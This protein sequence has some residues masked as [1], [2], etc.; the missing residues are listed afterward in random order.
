MKPRTLFRRGFGAAVAG[1]YLVT[2]ALTGASASAQSAAPKPGGVPP[3]T[4]PYSPVYH[5]PYRYGAVPT[6]AA[7][8]HMR[9]WAAAHPAAASSLQNMIYAGGNHGQ[10]VTDG[11]EQVYLVFFGSQW[12]PKGTNSKGD[13]TLFNDP[14]VAVPY[15]QELMKGLG[16]GGERWSGTMTQYCQGIVAGSQTCPASAAHVA[17]PTGGALAGVWAD[18]SNPSPFEA[19]GSQLAEEAIDAAAHFGNTTAASN[20]DAQY[21]IVSPT[22]T[23]PDGFN[24]PSGGFCAWHDFNADPFLPGGPVISPYGLIAFTNMPYATDMGGECG[25]FFISSTLDGFSIVEGHEYAETITDQ[26]P[27]SGWRTPGG[28]ETGD[29]CA[30]K[31]SGAGSIADLGL[32]TGP[33]AMQGTWSNDVNGG[34]GGCLFTHPIVS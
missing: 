10:G 25:E 1:A 20:R 23:H 6:L 28:S 33:F 17:Y 8:A 16:T 26:Y 5:H 21:V 30:W 19:T 2:A 7:A 3:V 18:E 32:T 15:L 31:I 12:G 22:G 13:L 11:H 34:N 24:T 27:S 14:S 29:L 9:H 4:D